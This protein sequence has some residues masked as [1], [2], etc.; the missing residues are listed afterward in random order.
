MSIFRRL[1][2]QSVS[3]PGGLVCLSSD[4][5]VF[6]VSGFSSTGGVSLFLVEKKDQDVSLFWRFFFQISIAFGKMI[7]DSI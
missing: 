1:A 2:A 5:C 4:V 6:L 3:Q 7:S